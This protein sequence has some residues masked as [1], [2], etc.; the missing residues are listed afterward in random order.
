M[1]ARRFGAVRETGPVRLS[2]RGSAGGLA[3]PRT[4]P[5]HRGG[6]GIARAPPPR[7]PPASVPRHPPA[8]PGVWRA[9][10]Q[11]P[12]TAGGWAS[13][14]RLPLARRPHQCHGI[15]RQCRGF[16]SCVGR[17]P[18]ALHGRPR[19]AGPTT[20]LHH[21]LSRSGGRHG[22]SD[23]RPLKRAEPNGPAVGRIPTSG[24]RHDC[25]NGSPEAAEG[26][27]ITRNQGQ[28]QRRQGPRP[29]P[30]KPPGAVPDCFGGA[31]R[32]GGESR[33]LQSYIL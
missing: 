31:G 8:V 32:G 14:V 5:P 1:P 29:G 21:G 16:V 22:C 12:R 4:N 15:P 9:R 24:L 6:M 10:E 30:P 11:T 27:R 20:A 25:Q 28:R 2:S 19:R 18:L 7:P 17:L 13:R 3:R 33:P 26:G 23:T